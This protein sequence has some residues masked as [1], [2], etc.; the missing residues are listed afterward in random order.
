MPMTLPRWRAP[1]VLG[2]CLAAMG[3]AAGAGVLDEGLRGTIDPAPSASPAATVSGLPTKQTARAQPVTRASPVGRDNQ[4]V[5][6][7][8][9]PRTV[10]TADPYA[11][12]GI[13]AGTFIVYP[14]V[15]SDVGYTTNAAGSAGGRPSTIVTV[16]PE[17]IIRSDWSRNS[18]SLTLR[19]S[20][21]TF[22][23]AT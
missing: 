13:R 17:V 10:S 18:A 5:G 12:L 3:T 16:R 20:Y 1:M 6:P 11:Q 22:S 7:V 2:A 14:A 4:A 9:G 8:E 23:R 19:G 21:E 15:E